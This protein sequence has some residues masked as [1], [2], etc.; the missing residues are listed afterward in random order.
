MA[1][2][3]R[4][5]RTR[6]GVPRSKGAPNIAGSCEYHDSPFLFNN[7]KTNKMERIKLIHGKEIESL[8]DYKD[9]AF[10]VNSKLQW[11]NKVWEVI[12]VSDACESCYFHQNRK[13]YRDGVWRQELGACCAIVRGDNMNVIFQLHRM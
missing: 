5:C 12:G 8:I 11:G 9:K 3:M 2:L 6:A 1:H 4:L 10:A 7:L 13:C